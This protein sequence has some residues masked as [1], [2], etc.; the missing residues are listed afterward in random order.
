MRAQKYT[1]LSKGLFRE[2][3]KK[4]IHQ[5][6]SFVRDG[7]IDP[8]LWFSQEIRPLFLLKE[9]YDKEGNGGWDLAAEHNRNTGDPEALQKHTTWPNISRWAY[10]IFSTSP[11]TLALYREDPVFSKKKNRYLQKIAVINVKKSGGKTVSQSRNL[12]EYAS[13]DREELLK[14]I[15]MIDPTVI[16]CGYTFSLLKII[17]ESRGEM[18]EC[19]TWLYKLKLQGKEIF[20]IDYYHPA[21]RRS[22]KKLFAKLVEVYQQ[23]LK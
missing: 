18:E 8:E 12:K 2:W 13:A 7:I 5:G 20:V 21:C 4:T 3:E 19:G 11:D 17:T 14:Q 22:K 23:T 1:E 9:A 15:E 10:G 16:I 6:Q